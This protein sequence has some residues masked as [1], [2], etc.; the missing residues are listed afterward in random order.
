MPVQQRND[1]VEVREAGR[2][3]QRMFLAER[4]KPVPLG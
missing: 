1:M 2:Q 4:L 3:F